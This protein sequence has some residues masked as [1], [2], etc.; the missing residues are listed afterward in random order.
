M[1]ETPRAPGR[2]EDSRIAQEV[3][4]LFDPP[5]EGDELR[6]P[7]VVARA[8]EAFHAAFETALDIYSTWG[9]LSDDACRRAAAIHGAIAAYRTA[10][11]PFEEQLANGPF[12]K[13]SYRERLGWAVALRT[14]EEGICDGCVLDAQEPGGDFKPVSAEVRKAIAA[15]G[16]DV[17]A[18]IQA[19]NDSR[20]SPEAKSPDACRSAVIAAGTWSH[21]NRMEYE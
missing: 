21:M 3:E 12:G 15:Y 8:H 4:R 19:W 13:G 14:A 2:D 5:E 9:H 6:W 11:P 18:N 17:V 1:S 7:G 20:A 10:T 16:S